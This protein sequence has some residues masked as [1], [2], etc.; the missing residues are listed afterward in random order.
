MD[1]LKYLENIYGFCMDVTLKTHMFS[2]L[3]AAARAIKAP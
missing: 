1:V 2:W 3:V